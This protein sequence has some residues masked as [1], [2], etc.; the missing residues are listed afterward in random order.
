MTYTFDPNIIT[1]AMVM[2]IR[3]RH[4]MS[5]ERFSQL[6]GFQ[7]KSTARLNNIEKNDSWKLGDREAVA[8]VLTDLEGGQFDPR[9]HKQVVTPTFDPTAS[10]TILVDLDEDSDEED[11]LALASAGI[12][13]PSLA[14][15]QA[16]PAPPAP[17]ASRNVIPL[18]S[19]SPPT[20]QTPFPSAPQPTK[21]IQLSLF[22][23]VAPAPDASVDDGVYRVSNGEM[24]SWKRCRRKWWLGWYRGMTLK[25]EGFVDVRSTGNRVHRAL[26]RWYVPENETR[27]DPRDA[28][29]RVIVEDWTKITQLATERG[30]RDD[31]RQ[32]LARQYAES[33]NLERAMIEGYVQWLEETGADAELRV[34]AS[35]TSLS[36]DLE[37]SVNGVDRPV[38]MIGLLD[39]RVY[40][41]TDNRRL[42]IDHKT[43]GEFSGPAVTLPQN[44]QMLHYD[45]LEFLNTKEG[46]E[47]CD[48]A[49]YNMLR[50]VKRS[51]RAK[52]PFYDRIEVHHNVR[53]LESYKRRMLATARDVMEAVDALDQGQHH[54]DVVY[55][56]PRPTCT[57][58]CDFFAMCT[59]FDDGSPGADDMLNTLYKKYDP[60]DRYDKTDGKIE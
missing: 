17:P 41:V 15:A 47:R 19:P 31:Q 18:S 29:E 56:S 27:V 42:F 51:A 48:G 54:L 23:G 4:K 14:R 16:W 1:G 6:A 8:R 26:E 55:P 28:L 43:V 45:L 40:R 44:E 52:P 38:R 35:E 50:R 37:T 46:E 33:N 39:A 3:Q 53:E 5:R 21:P 9:Y 13:T 25:H 20:T 36:A 34:I 57:W 22:D 58:D 30:M 49:L 60:R 11:L 12:V 24:Q 7:G 32:D 2:D 10:V 59:M